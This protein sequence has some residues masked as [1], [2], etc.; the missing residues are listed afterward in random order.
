MRQLKTERVTAMDNELE[1]LCETLVNEGFTIDLKRLAN[2]WRCLL[3]C[4]NS[5]LYSVPTGRA[6]TA[7]EAV[8]AACD[9]RL[10]LLLLEGN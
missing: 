1:K 4:D 2:G 3:Y 10:E 8:N 7:V 9:H 5:R 6:T